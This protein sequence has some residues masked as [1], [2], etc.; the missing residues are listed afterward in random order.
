MYGFLKRY[1]G[2][3]A[4]NAIAPLVYAMMLL[5]VTYC[6]FESQAEFNYLLL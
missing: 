5:A 4:A 1:L 3:R 2:T 6:I